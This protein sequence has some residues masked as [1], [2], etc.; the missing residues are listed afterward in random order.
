MIDAFRHISV[1]PNDIQRGSTHEIDFT[2][3]EEKMK[4]SME[5]WRKT[6]A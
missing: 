5:C 3:H 4:M 6:G 2:S 1:C